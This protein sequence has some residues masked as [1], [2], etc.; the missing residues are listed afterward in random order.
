[1]EIA[2]GEEGEAGFSGTFGRD[3][4]GLD[5]PG[6]S[7]MDSVKSCDEWRAWEGVS[8]RCVVELKYRARLGRRKVGGNA[9]TGI[10][11]STM[12]FLTAL[13]SILRINNCSCT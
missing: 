13:L 1:L 11:A 10:R 12:D 9:D 7:S 6:V 3:N 4:F 2:N 8:I 5:E